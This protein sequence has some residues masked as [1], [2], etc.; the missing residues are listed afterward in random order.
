MGL[1]GMDRITGAL[2]RSAALAGCLAVPHQAAAQ[3]GD[4]AEIVLDTVVVTGAGEG[5]QGKGS[6]DGLVADTST[7][8]S[9]S[10]LPLVETPQSVTVIGRD[11]IETLN[12]PTVSEALRYTP[13][14]ASD[15]YGVDTR[16]DNYLTIRGL[17]ANFLQ[18][19]LRLPTTKSYASWR[20]DPWFVERIELLRGPAS[21]LYGQGDPGGTVN[22]VSKRPTAEAF[23]TIETRVGSNRR[24]EVAMD[25]GGPLGADGVWSYRLPVVMSRND[26]T[27]GDPLDGR[28]FAAAP[29]ISWQPDAGT[30]LT[31]FSTVLLED[32]SIDANFLPARGTVLPNPNGPISPDRFTGDPPS[33]ATRRR[34]CR[35]ATSSS[36]RSTTPSSCAR[37]CATPTSRPTRA[38]ST[39]T[40]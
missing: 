11:R 17:T 30:S 29:S 9:K 7:A 14:I 32:T 33:T 28:R 23:A 40:G 6:V 1:R 27:G 13:G 15:V 10:P 12:L 2:L 26:L 3:D 16:S 31:L 38:P 4:T 35:S 24:L 20:V 37:T 18:D 36:T 21:I 39:A 8:G 5:T 34:R 25:T 19:G 22:Y